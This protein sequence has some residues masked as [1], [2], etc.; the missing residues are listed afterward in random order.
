MPQGSVVGPFLYMDTI[1][2]L[3]LSDGTDDIL[4]YKPISTELC[5]Q[6]LQ[7]WSVE[8]LKVQVHVTD[9]QKIHSIQL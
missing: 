8:N 1:S 6:E 2:L 4:I 5:Y 3:H 7:Q 9:T